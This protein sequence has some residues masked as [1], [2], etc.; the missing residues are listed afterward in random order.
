MKFKSVAM[1]ACAV[2]GLAIATPAAAQGG[3]EREGM[4]K[5]ADSWIRAIEKGSMFEMEL[6]EWTDYSENYKRASL[7]QFLDDPR[8]V[9]WHMT[10]IDSAACKVYVEAILL[11]KDGGEPMVMGTQIGTGLFLTGPFENI[12]SRKD[13]WLFSPDRTYYYATRED[14]GDIPE[15]ERQS[16]E[17]LIA[18]ADAYLDLFSDA[19][20]EVPWGTPCARLEGGIYTAKG[21]PTDSCNVGVPEGIAMAERLYVVDPVKG[22]V[23]VLLKMGENERPDSHTFRVENGK[24][25]YIHTITDCGEDVNCGFPP[26]DW[27]QYP[28]PE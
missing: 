28:L 13:D 17:E 25:R 5:I 11:G 23:N 16:R 14:W 27:T 2:A 4:Q 7:S 19:S 8:T 26:V 1:A 15:G 21:E 12:V 20:T 9:D 10:V 24:L 22:A 18:A 6:R 3:C